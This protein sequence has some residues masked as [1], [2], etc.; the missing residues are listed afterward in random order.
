MATKSKN[1]KYGRGTKLAALIIAAV[2]FFASGCFASR[3]VKGVAMYNSY[4]PETD[5][6]Q[7]TAFRGLMSES[8][9]HIICGAEYLNV[10]T[11]SDYLNTPTGK[12]ITERYQK[13]IDK[14][15]EAYSLLD[16]SGIAVS[17][18][19]ENRYRYSLEYNGKTYYFSHDGTIISYNEFNS[20]DYV[21]YYGDSDADASEDEPATAVAVSEP[22]TRIIGGETAQDT[23]LVVEM[24]GAVPAYIRQIS[25]ALNCVDTASSYEHFCYGETSLDNTVEQINNSKESEINANYNTWDNVIA[26]NLASTNELSFAVFFGSGEVVTNC[27]ITAE[28]T[29]EQIIKKLGSETFAEGYMNGEYKLLV[30]KPVPSNKASVYS[31][32]HDSLFKYTDQSGLQKFGFSEDEIKGAFFGLHSVDNTSGLFNLSK[33]AYDSFNRGK[34]ASPAKCLALF[35]V[36]FLIACAACI[37]LLFAAG[38]TADGIKINFFDKIPLVLNWAVGLTLMFC[39]GAVATCFV[40]WEFA[41]ASLIYSVGSSAY[42][43]GFMSFLF[44]A[45]AKTSTVCTA[46]CVALFFIIWTG[47]NMSMARNIRNKTF[48]RYTLCYWIFRPFRWLWKKAK[49]LFACDYSDGR[50]KKFRVIASISVTSFLIINGIMLLIAGDNINY[51]SGVF[52]TLFMIAVNLAVLIFCIVLIVS[53]DKIMAATS[54]IR[55]GDMNRR[56]NTDFMPGFLRRF[57]ADIL[58][59]SDGLQKAVDNATKD[60]RMK[61]ELI[62]NVSHDLK[63]PLT[64]I[65]NYVDL[66]KKCNVE[67]ETAQKY[68]SVLDEKAA[69]MKKLIEDL[70]EAS[71]ASSGAVEIHPVKLNLCEFAT[72]A[73]G[74]HE[75]ELRKYGIELVLKLPENLVMVNA[76]A[77][78]TSRIVENLFSNIRKYALEGTRVYIDVAEGTDFGSLVFKNISKSPLDISPDELTQRFVRGDAAR[79]GEGSGLGLSIAKD[80]CELQGGMLGLQIDGDLFK[81]TIA[82]PKAK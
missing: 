52:L 74:E 35:A 21:D 22:V 60:Q 53:L 25:K 28:D 61:A 59:M 32:L 68:I 79:T 29:E 40:V 51:G 17:I 34:I 64:S 56:I 11:R 26:K 80:L 27:G 30:G 47:L 5:Y 39:I 76:D 70:V 43:D 41:P 9:I 3:F 67:D 62:T 72:Q 7:T 78:K 19:G 8:E 33:T 20:Y 38:K 13:L 2:M 81:A 45:A 16:G 31:K 77:Q 4:S 37:Y 14:V 50:R 65:V 58:S 36:F 23:T 54:D 44:S 63:T 49:Q 10:N 6:T 24:D 55:K 42:D 12:E 46:L 48:F 73:V 75:D 66:L 15:T 82:L 18:D 1:I 57:S 71:K 69:K